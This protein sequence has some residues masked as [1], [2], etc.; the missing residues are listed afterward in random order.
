MLL[1]SLSF[2]KNSF[3]FGKVLH[4]GIVLRWWNQ[5]AKRVKL[6]FFSIC[7]G[8]RMIIGVKGKF[9]QKI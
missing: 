5:I 9:F 8:E 4:A 6:K 7:R 1:E 3:N 2:L